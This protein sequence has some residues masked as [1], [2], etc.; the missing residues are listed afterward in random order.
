MNF[1]S[2]SDILD[3]QRDNF[4]MTE[5]SNLLVLLASPDICW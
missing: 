3:I 4:N 2:L 1:P 5:P